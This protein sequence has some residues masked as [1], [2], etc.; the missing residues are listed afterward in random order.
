MDPLKRLPRVSLDHLFKILHKHISKG[1]KVVIWPDNIEQKD[2]ND[3]VM[4]NL[5]VEEIINYNTFQNLEA[6]LKYTNWRK[7]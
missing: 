2:I 5:D 3:M 4:A 1:H 7:C 6:E